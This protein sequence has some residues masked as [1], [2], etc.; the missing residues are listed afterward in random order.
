MS[1]Q[2]STERSVWVFVFTLCPAVT[3]MSLPLTS[4]QYLLW[5]LPI[6]AH[7]PD[8]GGKRKA[9]YK[10]QKATNREQSIKT[11]LQILTLVRKKKR[12][13]LKTSST[14]RSS[15]DPTALRPRT[16]EAREQQQNT[17]GHGDIK[18]LGRVTAGGPPV[19]FESRKDT[20]LSGMLQTFLTE[21]M[22][23]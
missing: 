6:T 2:Q 1:F 17:K 10:I 22:Q 19:L 9:W 14:T 20:I 12:K 18:W 7:F 4:Q 15:I 5:S 23:L 11:L 8:T 21:A 13:H 3:E 16:F